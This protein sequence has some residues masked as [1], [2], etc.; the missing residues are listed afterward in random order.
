MTTSSICDEYQN[1]LIIFINPLSEQRIFNLLNILYNLS[2]TPKNTLN[3]DI[4][5]KNTLNID[6]TSKIVPATS[7]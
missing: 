4:T 6:I 1:N 5:Y 7:P 2:I 3:S